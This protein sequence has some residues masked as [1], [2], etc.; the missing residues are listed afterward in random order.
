MISFERVAEHLTANVVT[1][2]VIAY[3]ITCATLETRHQL[4]F[5]GSKSTYHNLIIKLF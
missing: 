5:N 3:I 4:H 2:G 1:L